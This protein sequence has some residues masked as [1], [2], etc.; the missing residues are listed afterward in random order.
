M[1]GRVRKAASKL[2]EKQ[3]RFAREYI[4]DLN[5][6]QAAIRAGY[7][8]KTACEQG[9]RLLANVKVQ[10][11]VKKAMAKRQT[12]TQ[13]TQDKV[14]QELAAIAF[15]KG[16]DYASVTSGIA[17][18][19]DTDKLTDMQKAAI[20]S[21]K[22]T[23]DGVEIKLGNKLKALELLG[24]HLGMFSGGQTQQ[25]LEDEP[26]I[27]DLDMIEEQEDCEEDYSDVELEEE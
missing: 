23:R 25:E 24:K 4:V 11:A 13:I 26:A 21:I 16:T 18:P 8:K 17:I 14:L 22:A 20:V 12:R 9:A 7:S 5:A 15:A 10:E 6:T 1:C 27:D 3:K 2:T 19:N